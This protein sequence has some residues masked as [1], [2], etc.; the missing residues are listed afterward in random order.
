MTSNDCTIWMHRL[1]RRVC[2]AYHWVPYD[3]ALSAALVGMARALYGFDATLQLEAKRIDRKGYLATVDEL[4]QSRWIARPRVENRKH[5]WAP[6]E[7]PVF[8]SL[9]HDIPTDHRPLGFNELIESCSRRE[10]DMLSM[11]YVHN[12]NAHEI[13]QKFGCST[14]A[15]WQTTSA[16]RCKI[17]AACS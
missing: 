15:V 1:A 13:A 4:R 3:E 14:S 11:Q 16:A 12:L 9:R 2:R 10:R 8:V 5:R 17:K 7:R 6:V